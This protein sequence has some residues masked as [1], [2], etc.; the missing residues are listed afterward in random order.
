MPGKIIISTAFRR[1]ARKAIAG[2]IL[3]IVAYVTMLLAAL[4]LGAV[5][6]LAAARLV[7]ADFN[8][9]SMLVGLSLAVFGLMIFVFLLKFVL[10]KHKA[11]RSHLSEVMETDEPRLFALIHSTA[12]EVGTR[13]PKRVYFSNFVEAAVFYDSSFWSMLLPVR[14]NLQIGLGLINTTTVTELKGVIAHEFGHFSQQTMK[15]GSYVYYVNQVIFNLVNDNAGFEDWSRRLTRWNSLLSWT[16][17]L[18]IRVI[19]GIQWV[20]ARLFAIVNK[21]Y[22]GL[23]RE[24]EFQADEIAARITGSAPLK[25]ALLRTDLSDFSFGKVIDFFNAK[26]G[27][28]L[29]S[30]N[31][32]LNHRFVMNH[33]ANKNNYAF[34]NHFPV[35]DLE[36]I[37]RYNKSK[38]VVENQWASHPGLGE[39]VG[40]LE[41]LNIPSTHEDKRPANSILSNP[42][43]L[44]ER[45]TSAIFSRV[46][47]PGPTTLMTAGEFGPAFISH[48]NAL[49]LPECYNSY[50]DDKNPNAFY[51]ELVEKYHSTLSLAQLFSNEKTDLVYAAIGLK[52]DIELLGQ[53]ATK[54][55][56]VK[57]FDYDG[58]KFQSHEAAALA[59]LLKPALEEMELRIQQNDEE[60]Y[61]YFTDAEKR[62]GREP[63]LK[64]LYQDLFA[65]QNHSG[66]YWAEYAELLQ[67]VQF[68]SQ[69]TPNHIIEA[70]FAQAEDAEAIFRE[71]LSGLMNDP[72]FT[73][74]MDAEAFGIFQSY[75]ADK[76]HYFVAGAYDE[77]NVQT[78]F[79]I[80]NHFPKYFEQAY[81]FRKKNL[82]LYQEELI[83]LN[84]TSHS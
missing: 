69:P 33:I 73:T 80:L 20:L 66:R 39:R 54:E 67:R 65:Y 14:K 50:Y 47:Y 27:E 34:E 32:F 79:F 23:A 53:I 25:N 62:A 6:L 42:E 58:R 82:L 43:Q 7:S 84:S 10:G 26:K 24:M 8:I 64:A 16:V 57:S 37:N 48:V 81:H 55:V 63:L 9:F 56:N 18:N 38:M 41:A 40:R 22:F 11:D 45:Q 71:T 5:C 13:P 31:L 12:K 17:E 72:F 3:F 28:N 77:A 75:L 60:I 15:V 61:R 35:V 2:V 59:E 21:R 51:P 70:G 4:A 49:Q 36:Q 44:Q 74:E 83:K 78:L 29:V 68:V 46:E 52:F 1:Q 76:L 30:Q 19:R